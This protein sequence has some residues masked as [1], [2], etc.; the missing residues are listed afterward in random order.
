M[1]A[2]TTT[3]NSHSELSQESSLS[4]DDSMLSNH[5][6]NGMSDIRDVLEGQQMTS[7]I[8]G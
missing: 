3:F 7:M 2:T 8:D 6:R 5:R 4:S 1:S